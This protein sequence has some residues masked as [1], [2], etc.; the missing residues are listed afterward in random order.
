MNT[1]KAIK[2]DPRSAPNKA[3]AAVPEVVD[4]EMPEF[5]MEKKELVYPGE[6]APFPVIDGR[7][8]PTGGPHHP[9]APAHPASPPT[10]VPRNKIHL[11]PIASKALLEA[12]TDCATAC[13]R[14]IAGSAQANEPHR[15]SGCITIGRACA[16]ICILLHSYVVESHHP[17]LAALS[18]DLAL[19][20]GR[21]CE[22]CAMECG[23]HP[24]MPQF[25]TC[26]L[27][28]RKCAAECRNYAK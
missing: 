5:P 19:T 18:K 3:P 15:F 13:E 8:G 10:E 20:C 24:N 22:T 25:A 6:G 11:M 4:K 9:G 28:C 12:L 21:V 16:D 27:A 17:E 1:G 26:E 2:K 7:L 23:K 14:C